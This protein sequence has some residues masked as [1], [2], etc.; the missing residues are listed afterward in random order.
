LYSFLS[1]GGEVSEDKDF[2][3]N[4]LIFTS[5]SNMTLS[6]LEGE[7][8]KKDEKECE[9]PLHCAPPKVKRKQAHRDNEKQEE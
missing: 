1:Q 9:C 8:N 7:G 6:E 5:P 4:K 2:D 3:P